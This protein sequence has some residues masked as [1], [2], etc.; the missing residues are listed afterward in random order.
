M[1]AG[2]ETGTNKCEASMVE[3]THPP[4]EVIREHMQQRAKSAEPPPSPER[5]RQELGWHL[6]PNNRRR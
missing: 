5:I 4:K 2:T 6:L 1:Q 3:A